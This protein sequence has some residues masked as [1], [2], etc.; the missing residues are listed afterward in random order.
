MSHSRLFREQR[1]KP[2]RAQRRSMQRM[3]KQ[4]YIMSNLVYGLNQTPYPNLW[5]ENQLKSLCDP[6]NLPALRD[7]YDIEY[8]LLTDQE[9]LDAVSRHPNFMKLSQICAV[10]VIKMAWPPDADRFASRYGL[11]CQLFHQTLPVALEQKALLSVWVADLVFAQGSLP[12][13]LGHLER[14]HDAVFNVP[15][16]SAADALGAALAQ[17]PGA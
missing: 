12:K 2:N 17:L 3:S 14:G 4:K 10:N 8:V 6:T 15:I 11:L 13:M 5:L 1:M 9:T 7:R 16:R